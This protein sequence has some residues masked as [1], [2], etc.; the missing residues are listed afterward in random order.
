DDVGRWR[1]FILAD[2]F[3]LRPRRVQP[4]VALD[5]IDRGLAFVDGNKRAT[6]VFS[7]VYFLIPPLQ[8]PAD[9]EAE[10]FVFL[11]ANA[12]IGFAPGR[13]APAN[14]NGKLL[15]GDRSHVS[16]SSGSC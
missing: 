6:G 8:L 2:R 10:A 15:F 12:E 5:L 7:L 4:N 3:A 11:L 14:E 1:V 16:S 13:P 9:I